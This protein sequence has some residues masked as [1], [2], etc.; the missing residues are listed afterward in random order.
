MTLAEP[1]AGI[2]L[3]GTK[4]TA[5][6]A[7]G[8]AIVDRFTI[9]TT[10]PEA[11]LGAL[12]AKLL[13]WVRQDRFTAIGVA[14]FGPIELC[15]NGDKY[16]FMRRTPKPGWS[17]ADVLSPLVRDL[18]VAVAL[19]TDVNG[20]ALAEWRWQ[21]RHL[22]SL[23]YITVG[24]GVGVGLVYRGA[25]IQ[26]ALHPEMGHVRLRRAEGDAYKGGCVYHGDC[27]EGLISGPALLQRFGR[28]LA[29]RADDEAW[30]FVAHDL[31]Q[32]V[33]A[34]ILCTAPQRILIGGGIGL[35]RPALLEVVRAKVVENLCGYIADFNAEAA[36]ARI[37]APYL[38]A[39]AGPLG[40][41]ALAYRALEGALPR[42][43]QDV[44]A[45]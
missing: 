16:G 40:A 36:V 31:A 33:T 20:A 29:P 23:A 25:T 19:D 7:R 5:V 21:A 11:T 45:S 42:H 39:D 37:S 43:R 1:V 4:A 15:P 30:T 14:S 24:T 8:R 38:G 44:R 41:I 28:L 35:A 13:E 17:D 2:E 3:G 27:V 22:E 10:T 12:N 34:L 32:L 18:D 26:G 9:A 6:L